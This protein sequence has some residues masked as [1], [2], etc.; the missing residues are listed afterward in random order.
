M[1]ASRVITAARTFAPRSRSF[2]PRPGLARAILG[3]LVGFAIGGG[4]AVELNAE[5][6]QMLALV[7]LFGL[8]GFLLGV[9]A[10][11]FWLTGRRSRDRRER[12]ARGARTRR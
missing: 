5:A 3:A 1:I 7:Y 2:V 4:L 10:F 11:R 8:F 6:G 12:G 9:G